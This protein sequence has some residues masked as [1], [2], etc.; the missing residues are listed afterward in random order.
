MINLHLILKTKKLPS[1][2]YY[3][4]QHI[5]PSIV[6]AKQPSTHRPQERRLTRNRRLSK[7]TPHH[8]RQRQTQPEMAASRTSPYLVLLTHKHYRGEIRAGVAELQRLFSITEHLERD[9]IQRLSALS[10]DFWFYSADFDSAQFDSPSG[11][12]GAREPFRLGTFFL[13]TF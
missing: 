11:T 2:L 8:I 6:A 7:S 10:S 3:V 1:T 9:F 13:G 12:I 4:M 5:L